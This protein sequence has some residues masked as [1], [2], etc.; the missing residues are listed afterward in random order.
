MIQSDFRIHYDDSFIVEVDGSEYKFHEIRLYLPADEFL[1]PLRCYLRGGEIKK[2]DVVVDAGAYIGIF[3]IL[4]S[5]IVGENGR[6]VSFEPDTANFKELVDNIRLNGLRNVIPLN[7]ALWSHDTELPFRMTGEMGS[8][9]DIEELDSESCVRV[10]VVGLDAELRRFNIGN[11]DFVKMDV[12]GAEVE[13]LKGS[14]ETL[15]KNHPSL[16]IA[17]YH[18]VKGKQ[19]YHEVERLLRGMGYEVETSCVEHSITYAHKSPRE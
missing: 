12:E 16:A 13:A 10:P 1:M 17:S 2:G 11:V 6:V 15:R 4:A 5:R 19:T 3:T 9:I 7:K 8:S 14:E 18:V